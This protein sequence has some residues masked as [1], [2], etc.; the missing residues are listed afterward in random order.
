MLAKTA[1][2]TVTAIISISVNPLESLENLFR[3]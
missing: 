2:I 3:I 1:I